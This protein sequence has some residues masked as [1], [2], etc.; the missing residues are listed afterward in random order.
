MKHSLH[1]KTECHRKL[2]VHDSVEGK[3]K[4]KLCLEYSLYEHE[5]TDMVVCL[6][7]EISNW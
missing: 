5:I 4:A 2:K 3:V 1:Y 7:S 6:R